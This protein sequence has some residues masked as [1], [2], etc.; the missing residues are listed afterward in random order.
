MTDPFHRQGAA[1]RVWRS[2]G[3]GARGAEMARDVP[4]W[5][6][7]WRLVAVLEEIRQRPDAQARQPLDVRGYAFATASTMLE[8]HTLGMCG[9]CTTVCQ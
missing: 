4:S 8:H 1:I 9:G 5:P 6:A 2:L 7:P 3:D